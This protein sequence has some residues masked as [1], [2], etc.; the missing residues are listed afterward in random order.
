MTKTRKHTLTVH[1][2]TRFVKFVLTDIV[3][4][5]SSGQ[6]KVP[7]AEQLYSRE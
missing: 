2:S 7:I 5:Y 6:N 1:Y 3:L 4:L